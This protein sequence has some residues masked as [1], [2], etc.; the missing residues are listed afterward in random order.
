MKVLFLCPDLNS[1]FVFESIRSQV[2]CLDFLVPTWLRTCAELGWEESEHVFLVS[3][4]EEFAERLDVLIDNQYD[5]IFAS[6]ADF[7]TKYIARANT[8]KN[9]PGINTTT[10]EL[11]DQKHKY[12]KVFQELEIPF[13]KTYRLDKL[14][15]DLHFP[16]IIKPTDGTA[17]IGVKLLHKKME[18]LDYGMLGH[19][20][21]HRL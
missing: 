12:F 15:N 5:Q 18:L 20:L 11:I 4:E 17:G 21:L 7:L 14:A 13:P 3:D 9:L 10:S 2:D 1:R 16:V 8:R 19:T 6:Q